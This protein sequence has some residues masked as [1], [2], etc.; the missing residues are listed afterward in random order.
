MWF[1]VVTTGLLVSTLLLLLGPLT[2]LVLWAAVYLMML[3]ER[4][5]ETSQ[6]RNKAAAIKKRAR[7]EYVLRKV[8]H[9][10]APPTR[11]SLRMMTPPRQKSA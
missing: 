6:R 5:L 3:R 8:L 1:S 7:R 11:H 10:E 2:R 4:S 9:E